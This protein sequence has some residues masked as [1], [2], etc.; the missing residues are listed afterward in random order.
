M[1]TYT[2]WWVIETPSSTGGNLFWTGET[3]SRSALEG[4]RYCRKEDAERTIAARPDFTGNVAAYE[5]AWAGA[6]MIH[7]NEEAKS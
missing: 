1:E 2:H 3:W 5:H 6:P 4:L 7:P